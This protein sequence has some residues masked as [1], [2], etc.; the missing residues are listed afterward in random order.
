MK[1]IK[2]ITGYSANARF[3]AEVGKVIGFIPRV[4]DIES[5]YS[6]SPTEIVYDYQGKPII[7]K[8]TKHRR[9]E[10]F[11][12]PPYTKIWKSETAL[13]KHLFG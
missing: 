3:W 1:R 7:Q 2:T 6:Y 4:K 12:V 9:Y 8:E 13:E 5:P 10:V 11:V